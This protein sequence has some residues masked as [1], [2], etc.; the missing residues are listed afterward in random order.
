MGRPSKYTKERAGRILSALREGN[1]RSASA[2]LGGIDVGTLVSWERRFSD[3]SAHVKEAEAAAERM[4]VGNI[5]R[6]AF[7]GNWQASAW[8][9]ERRRPDDWGRKD[10]LEVVSLVRQM[11][12]EAG[13]DEDETKAAVAEAEKYL[14][15]LGSSRG[16]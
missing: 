1:T 4:H 13:L 5:K 12:A 7:S 3:F 16:R 11:A 10:R 9:L 15:S 2:A 6:A 14:E 8:W